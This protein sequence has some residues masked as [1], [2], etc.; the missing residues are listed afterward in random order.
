MQRNLSHIGP[1]TWCGIIGSTCL[2]IFLFQKILWLVVP[3]LLALLLYYLL[4][5]LSKKLVMAGLSSGFATTLLSGGF[6]IMVICALLLVYP[7][8]IANAGEWQHTLM[9]YLEGG[10]RA[11]DALINA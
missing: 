6:L 1:I 8:I 7:M 5:P 2:L 3:F 10:S 11:F 9:R 4:S